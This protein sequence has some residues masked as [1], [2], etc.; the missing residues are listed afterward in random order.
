MLR[1]GRAFERIVLTGMGSSLQ[2][3]YP[4][5]LRMAAAGLSVWIVDTADLLDVGQGLIAGRT[6]VWATSQSGEAA[7]IVELLERIRGRPGVVIL[8]MTNEP[9]STLGTS[10]QVIVPLHSGDEHTVATR[11]YLNTLASSSLAA[12]AVLGTPGDPLLLQAPERIA[13]YLEGWDDHLVSIAEAMPELPTFILGRAAAL[14]TARMAGLTIKE[15]SRHATEGMSVSQFR[16]GP[17]E[18]AGPGVTVIILA[19]DDA[20]DR[21]R[22]EQM[23]ADLI[24]SGARCV[25]LD[26]EPVIHPS[27]STP[28]LTS[29]TTRPLGDIVPLQLLTI[30]LAERNGAEAG[31][32]RQIGKVTRV[33]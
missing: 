10:A 7:E 32:F 1:A 19:G 27:I 22:N 28:L 13:R 11:S 8:G 17:L 30:V 24:S 16:H 33:L 26:A 29:T 2:G 6:L 31:R 15:A 4:A 23:R 21:R 18:M 12:D 20:L 9:E 14:G 25:W 5:Y 3:M